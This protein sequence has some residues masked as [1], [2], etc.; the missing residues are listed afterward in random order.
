MAGRGVTLQALRGIVHAMRGWPTPLGIAINSIEQKAFA[1]D[2]AV[3]DE[4]IAAQ[5]RV[6]ATQI[7]SFAARRL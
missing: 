4:G 5:L 3:S 2:G 1:P 7:L 6:Q